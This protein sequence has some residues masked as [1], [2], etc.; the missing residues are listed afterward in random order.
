MPIT[1][2]A[3]RGTLTPEGEH[4]VLPRLTAEL[5]EV[6]GLTG[7][8]FFEAIV[9]GTV[10]VLDPQ[11]IYAG[12]KPAPVVMVELKLPAVGLPDL[13]SREAFIQRATAVVE[14]LTV[15]GHDPH[16]TWVNVLN[17][18]DGAWGFDGRSWTNEMLGAAI[19]QAA[20]ASA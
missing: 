19:S 2:T 1:V 3:P 12:G 6:F 14:E 20:G 11:D 10:H 13:A 17:A 7:N 4:Q 18:P 5:I 9:G 15:D 16:N 8:S